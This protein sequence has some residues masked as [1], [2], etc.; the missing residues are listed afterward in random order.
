[1]KMSRLL[2]LSPV[3]LALSVSTG[4]GAAEQEQ[5]PGGSDTQAKPLT[6]ALGAGAE[7]LPSWLGAA[8]SKTRGVPYININWQERVEFST[9]D[10][11]VIDL[12][13]QDRWHGGLVGTMLWGRSR[14]DLGTLADRGVPTLNNT[15]QAGTYLEYDVTKALSVGVRL[16]H[17]IQG[18]GAAYGDIYASLDLPAV[19]YVEHSLRVA[20]EAMNRT[21][22]RRFFGVSSEAAASLGTPGYRPDGGLSQVSVTYDAFI[23]T[24]Q[25]TGVAFAASYGRLAHNA[26]DSPLVQDFGRSSQRSLMAAF[27]YHF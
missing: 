13:H 6:V 3:L 21:A 23:P 20:G 26:A 24:S 2:A 27:V 10:G 22:M 4:A 17:D 5:P 9:V 1:M 25:S 11:L 8:D 15:L 16:R 7:R 14:S 12:V 18:T 19:G